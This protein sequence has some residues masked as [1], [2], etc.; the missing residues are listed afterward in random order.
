MMAVVLAIMMP[1]VSEN[2]LPIFTLDPPKSDVAI[3]RRTQNYKFIIF[4]F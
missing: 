1:L 3:S 4:V 2:F